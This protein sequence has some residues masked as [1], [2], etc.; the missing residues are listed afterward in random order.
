MSDQ[1]DGGISWTD[2]T[3]NPIRGCSR[4]SE[5]CRNC[6][7]EKVAGRF[8][9]PGLPYEGLV[10]IGE[11]GPRWN[12]TVRLVPEHLG[13]PLR[14]KRPRRVFVNSMSDLFHESLPFEAIA[15]VFGVMAAAPQH[16]FQVLTKRPKRALQ[17]F[18]WAERETSAARTAR[19]PSRGQCSWPSSVGEEGDGLIDHPGLNRWPL[20]NVWLGVSVE[21]QAT[22][23]ERI[24]LLLKCPAAV[25]WV[26]YEPALG[27]VNFTSIKRALF[28]RRDAIRKAMNGPAALNGDQ[29]D[30]CIA[31]PLDWIVVGGE[32]GPGARPFDLAWAR[33]V[34]AQCQSAEVPCFVKQLGADPREACERCSAEGHCEAQRVHLRDRKGGD[35]SEWPE[36]L[37]VRQWPGGA[38]G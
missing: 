21:D 5:G 29:A 12:G 24:P 36:G 10:T 34:V 17:F 33:S 4:V 19:G 26:S 7:A 37:R 31:Y 6:Y 38:H 1:R 15:A 16:T 32:S 9:G 11:K 27:L 20:P 35:M 13:D 8:S 14:W 3:W 23:D 2:E 18:A 30:A 22:A 28:N 25:R